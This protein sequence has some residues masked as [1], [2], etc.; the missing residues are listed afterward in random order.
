M[1]TFKWNQFN[2]NGAR[3]SRDVQ[4]Y[5]CRSTNIVAY[6]I[7][8]KNS[9]L[10]KHKFVGDYQP[11]QNNYGIYFL[12]GD[13]EQNNGT[14]T[15]YIGQAT[16]RDS[17]LGMGRLV[18][19]VRQTTRD[20]YKNE[21]ESALY[22][23]ST[24]NSWSTA[25]ID[26]LEHLFIACFKNEEAYKCLNSKSG[27]N[28]NIPEEQFKTELIAILELLDLP[29][30]G[31]PIS[32]N[33]K[34]GVIKTVYDK[35]IEIAI[36]AKKEL[37]NDLREEYLKQ[38]SDEDKKKLEWVKKAEVYNS[39]K[40]DIALA[41]NYVMQGRIYAGSKGEVITPESV[42]K[43]MVDMIPAKVF[44][45]KA[46]F[47]DPACKSEIYLKCLINRF[48]SDDDNL[49]INHEDKYKNKYTR[50]RHLIEK[51]LYG[52]CLSHNGCMVS[53]KR[54]IEVIE[55]Y[56][57]E[58]N[59]GNFNKNILDSILVIPNIIYIKNYQEKVKTHSKLLEDTIKNKFNMEGEDT[60]KFD[61]ILGNPPYNN[62][63]YI[64]FVIDA[65]KSSTSCVCMI[66]PAKWQAKEDNGK[67][68]MNK[69]FREI[70]STYA[71]SIV[72]YKDSTEVFEIEE[73]GGICYFMLYKDKYN[74]RLIKN[75]CSRNQT[76]A[77]D[78][79][80]HDETNIVLLNHKILNIIGKVGTLGDGFKQSLYVK[81]ID[82]G[83]KCIADALGFKQCVFTSEQERGEALKQ[84][85]YVEVMQ[86]E[87]CTGYKSIKQLRTK[88][89]LDKYKCIASIMPGAVAAF[90]KDNK[91][92]GMFKIS[93]I[94][95][96][97]VPKGSF[98]VLYYFDTREECES[99]I[100]YMTR[101]LTAF[102]YYI[103]TCGTTLT[104]EFFRFVPNPVTFDHIFTD[105][106]L[107]KKYNLTT[108]E[109]NIIES[110]IKDRK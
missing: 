96:Y 14:Q 8:D 12:M 60:L 31:Y 37:T 11:L 102:L 4:G 41:D 56:E 6:Y 99:F 103:G 29:I 48:M 65:H 88:L 59:K 81:N 107:Y 49:P 71:N 104:K 42:A 38:Y 108:E 53:N 101:K 1:G 70:M 26:T 91:V 94:G 19:H 80:I 97:Q 61:V 21:W 85:G 16:T 89:N 82:H 105:D 23:T 27:K 100:S 22:V 72:N 95:P 43:Q 63:L 10:K 36:E 73:W 110:V 98:P 55:S 90:D 3:I 32:K 7:Q 68:K 78:Y 84:A 44:N 39:F 47:L 86:G 46:T 5:K 92:L 2:G 79:E 58:L 83:E 51:Q 13:K 109:I 17:E 52:I 62:D 20:S 35:L 57:Y 24:D 45:S 50:L 9:I 74:S 54:I 30:F 87:K 64:K 76:L 75:I 77:S 33:N 106:E 67:D 93:I 15:I 28:G 34:E 18:E 69:Q 66:T 25:L 40:S